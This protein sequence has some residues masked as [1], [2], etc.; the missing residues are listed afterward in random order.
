M[1]LTFVSLVLYK[2]HLRTNYNFQ[3]YFISFYKKAPEEEV[4]LTSKR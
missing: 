3:F 2:E 1:T 4:G